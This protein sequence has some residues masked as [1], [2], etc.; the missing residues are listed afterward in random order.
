MDR[1]FS[2]KIPE[3]SALLDQ[4]TWPICAIRV[5]SGPELRLVA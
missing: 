4:T 1:G 2:V 5:M 3:K